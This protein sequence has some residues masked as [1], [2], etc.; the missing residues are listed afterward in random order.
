MST[1]F[2]RP[3]RWFA[4]FGPVVA[5]LGWLRRVLER[6]AVRVAMI[7]LGL[8]A[9][10]ASLFQGPHPQP[11]DSPHAWAMWISRHGWAAAVVLAGAAVAGVGTV[12]TL[13]PSLLG[14]LPRGPRDNL[15]ARDSEQDLARLKDRPTGLLLA[16]HR[17][18]PFID[19][20]HLL[21]SLVDWATDRS[22]RRAQGRLYPAPG[23]FGKT[24]LGI[25]LVDTLRKRRWRCTFL[26]PT[27]APDQSADAA[28]SLVEP[29]G[30]EGVLIVADYAEGQIER[31]KAIADAAHLES[32][33]G[34]P[35]RILA[36]ARSAEGWWDPFVRDPG[37]AAVFDFGPH[38]GVGDVWPLGDRRDLYAEARKVL[39]ARLGGFG[40]A[41]ASSNEPP[42]DLADRAYDRPLAIV[43]R[44]FL[45]ARGVVEPKETVFET[46][47]QEE[48]RHWRRALNAPSVDA[49]AL[50]RLA[51]A[52]A[53]VTLVQGAT[54]AAVRALVLADPAGRESDLDEFLPALRRLYG[55]T[56]R[57]PDGGEDRVPGIGPIEPDLLGE[58]A[59]MRV[60]AED[61]DGLA[62]ATLL[63]SLAG[64]PFSPADP[65]AI[66]TVLVRSTRP[67]H[68]PRVRDAA[69]RSIQALA[70]SV[71]G[72]NP[73]SIERLER[74]L[75]EH[76]VAL[77]GLAAEVAQRVSGMALTGG[78]DDDR[79]K[80]AR[81]LNNLGIR[82]SALGRRE[83]AHAASAEAVEL[84]RELVAKNRDAF[85]PDLASSLN[86]LG[87][88]LSSLGRR[89]EAHAASA[90]AVDLY[91]ELV[92]KN[93][94]AFLPDLASSLNNL[95][96]RCCQP[97]GVAR[98]RTRPAPRRW[99]SKGAGR[100]EPRRVPARSGFVPEQSGHTCQPL[101]VARRRTRPAPRRWTSIGSW[102]PRTATRSCP[103]W[104][105]P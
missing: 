97:L 96:I 2:D 72:L 94:D 64:R 85:L 95:G 4:R 93:R 38:Q 40:L 24:R 82:L 79:S 61:R 54:E 104:L 70:A 31:L 53:Q 57:D 15:G 32:P 42:V 71:P 90:E 39:S 20:G 56:Y 66:L 7:G 84:Y 88:V 78:S 3:R 62:P 34:P 63:A 46:L 5:T 68:E 49:A 99:T 14:G 81:A 36:F 87:V 35:I 100:Q 30:D 33:R 18:V 16:R 74:A 27:N 67:E 48:R 103:I 21:R 6:V 69:H 25:E 29:R 37:P 41:A 11:L 23:G 8:V 55:G 76:S 73:G 10:L 59:A 60:L 58:H 101:G 77:R 43:A 13:F 45:A 52:A 83:E 51:R 26:S 1:K 89:E 50:D 102:S 28:R 75:P 47:Y 12:V 105:R 80:R 17:V 86:N 9:A 44:A 91:R 19:R 92:A 22:G 98:R 65:S